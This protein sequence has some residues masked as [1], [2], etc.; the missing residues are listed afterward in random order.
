MAASGFC[1]AGVWIVKIRE[2]PDVATLWHEAEAYL[3]SDPANNTHQLSA[4]TRIM[5]IGARYGER[6][7]A[8]YVDDAN[9]D[10][11]KLI[12]SAIYVDSQALFLAV[13]S[14]DCARALATYLRYNEVRLTGVIGRRDVLAAFTDSYALPFSLHVNLMLY[15]LASA[16]AYGRA[17]GEARVATM[18]DLEVHVEWHRAL[19]SK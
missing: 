5:D 1:I 14:P 16:P 15:Q 11:D 8:V 7:F 3:S 2:L 12:A 17:S 9:G 10:F 13:M 18:H 6:F 19:R 4:A